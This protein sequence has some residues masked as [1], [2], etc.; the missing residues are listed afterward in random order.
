MTA[1]RN[2][3]RL[4]PRAAASAIVW[5]D[6]DVLLIE[7]GNGVRRGQWSLPGGHIEAG[8]RAIEAAAREVREETGVVARLD[9]LVDVHDVLIRD[10]TGLLTAHYVL[11]VYSGVA[12][13]GD[14][15]AA[16]DAIAA[17]FVA[18]ETLAQFTLTPGVARLVGRDRVRVCAM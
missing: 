10:E 7:R 12:L 16:S 3:V 1:P 6:G 14:P 17:R 13:S 8:E 15:I 18:P 5:R 9:A 2:P 11:V 4:L